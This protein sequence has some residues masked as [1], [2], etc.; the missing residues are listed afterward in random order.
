MKKFFV[1]VE[2]STMDDFNYSVVEKYMTSEIVKEH[3]EHQRQSF[4][5]AYTTFFFNMS[6][7]ISTQFTNVLQDALSKY[8][9]PQ[10]PFDNRDF[11]N[12][13]H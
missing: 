2:L 10:L 9:F 8:L 5:T 6:K 3:S 4:L 13:R 11:K 7:W 1:E 12:Y